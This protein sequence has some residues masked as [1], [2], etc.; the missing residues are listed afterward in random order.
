MK[1]GTDRCTNSI[2]KAHR[3]GVR[4]W[5]LSTTMNRTY[6]A[7]S[8]IGSPDTQG[9]RAAQSIA[10]GTTRQRWAYPVDRAPLL[11]LR[12]P[13]ALAA[14][15]ASRG[16]LI[17]VWLAMRAGSN[18]WPQPRFGNDMNKKYANLGLNNGVQPSIL[19]DEESD[20]LFEKNGRNHPLTRMTLLEKVRSSLKKRRKATTIDDQED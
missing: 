10:A 12:A 1:A 11:T 15:H 5:V 16:V 2:H 19:S 13:T 18:S 7:R 14:L 6:R 17:S 4:I 8:Q 9:C 20:A 3:E